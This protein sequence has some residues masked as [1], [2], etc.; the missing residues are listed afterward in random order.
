MN[1]DYSDSL[2]GS[3]P[4]IRRDRSNPSSWA[5]SHDSSTVLA[6]A[7]FFGPHLD[8]EIE[9]LRSCHSTQNPPQYPPISYNDYISWWYDK[10]Y[11]ANAQEDLANNG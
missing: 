1:G 3:P 4:S 6:I 11:N 5:A 7:F 2:K 9:C 8:T 10:N